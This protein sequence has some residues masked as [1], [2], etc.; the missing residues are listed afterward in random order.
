M[1]PKYYFHKVVTSMTWDRHENVERFQG[2]VTSFQGPVTRLRA[3]KIEEETQRN[4][5]GRVLSHKSQ[6]K[7][8]PDL[9]P[10]VLNVLNYMVEEEVMGD[11]DD[12]MLIITMVAIAIG[13]LLLKVHDLRDKFG[14][15]D[16]QEV[17]TTIGEFCD[18][19]CKKSDYD[20]MKEKYEGGSNGRR[21]HEILK[22]EKIKKAS[23]VL[24]KDA[25]LEKYCFNLKCWHDILHVV[26]RVVDSFPSWAP[27]WGMIPNFL[28]YY[29]G[30]FLVKNVEGYLYSLIEDLLDKSIRRIVETYSYIKSSF[31]TLVIALKGIGPFGNNFLNVKTQLENP[32]DNPK[33]LIGLEVLKAFLIGTILVLQFYLLHFEESMF[34]VNL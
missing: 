7:M 21:C 18:L 5:S 33:F 4:M 32:C 16:Y 6:R 28:D 11:L 9:L 1:K 27:M 24:T 14:I 12:T 26:F 15:L 29:V 31:E 30:K 25:K 17:E 19:R 8:A 10:M 3:R 22:E 34:F 13:K 2:L 23:R 20:Y